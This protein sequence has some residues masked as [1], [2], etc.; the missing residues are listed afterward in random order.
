MD[1]PHSKPSQVKFMSSAGEDRDENEALKKKKK[2]TVAENLGTLQ[3][4]R[5]QHH[6]A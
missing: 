6:Q 5:L 1:C 4:S 2:K 3:C